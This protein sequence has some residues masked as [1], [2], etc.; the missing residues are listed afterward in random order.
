MRILVTG[1]G[2]IIGYGVLR[3]RQGSGFHQILTQSVVDLPRLGVV[4]M[5]P[6]LLWSSRR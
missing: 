2:A 4:N 1:V 6:A 5:D 3:S